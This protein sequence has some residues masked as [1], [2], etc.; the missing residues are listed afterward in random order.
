[1][2]LV[3]VCSIRKCIFAKEA[4]KV[5]VRVTAINKLS[6]L[7]TDFPCINFKFKTTYCIKHIDYA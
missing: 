1:M 2:H 4:N 3:K 7:L 5:E 6:T